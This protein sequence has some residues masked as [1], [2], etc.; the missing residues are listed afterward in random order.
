MSANFI[1]AETAQ[2][3]NLKISEYITKTNVIL[4][5][6]SGVRPVQYFRPLVHICVE[7][8]KQYASILQ[9]RFATEP[10]VVVLRSMAQEALCQLLDRSVDS[11]F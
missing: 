3:L 10:G 7:P 2:E 1:F 11:V 6:G 5:I 8:H 4:D 9:N